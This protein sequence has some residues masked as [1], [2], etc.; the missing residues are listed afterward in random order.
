MKLGSWARCVSGAESDRTETAS[1]ETI[2]CAHR[3]DPAIILLYSVWSYRLFRRWN[4]EV[5]FLWKRSK[6]SFVTCGRYSN[7]FFLTSQLKWLV[8][9]V[10]HVKCHET[11]RP[12]FGLEQTRVSQKLLLTLYWISFPVLV[13]VFFFFSTGCWLLPWIF[14]NKVNPVLKSEA[15]ILKEHRKRYLHPEGLIWSVGAK[16]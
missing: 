1:E 2:S 14:K 4:P 16:L 15:L 8:F 6:A 7:V 10:K 11:W 13:L 12:S 9:V 3:R 5:L